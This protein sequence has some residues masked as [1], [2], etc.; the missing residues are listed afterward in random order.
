MQMPRKNSTSTC[1]FFLLGTI[2]LLVVPGPTHMH[3]NALQLQSQQLKDLGSKSLPQLPGKI[4]NSRTSLH[5]A[6]SSVFDEEPSRPKPKPRPVMEPP[7][8][9]AGKNYIH[10]SIGIELPY[11]SS[12]FEHVSSN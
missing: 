7:S 12:N 1:L 5:V 4:I 10:L 3:V 6:S 8:T 9:E 2:L 11:S